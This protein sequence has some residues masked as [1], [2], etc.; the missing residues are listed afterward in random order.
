M[1]KQ[2]IIKIDC[3]KIS[4]TFT[5][6]TLRARNC[7]ESIL[8]FQQL[9]SYPNLIVLYKHI[10]DRETQMIL[11]TRLYVCVCGMGIISY[12]NVIFYTLGNPGIQLEQRQ[13]PL[14]HH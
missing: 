9:K 8:F 1:V 14:L 12:S 7:L 5:Y 3:I 4:I 10:V 13:N 2:Y 11:C 6:T